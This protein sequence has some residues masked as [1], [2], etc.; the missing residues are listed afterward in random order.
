MSSLKS[1]SRIRNPE[2]LASLGRQLRRA[3]EAAGLAQSSVKNM[4]QGT[5]SKIENGLEVTLDTFVTYTTSL[6]L[7]I[8]LVPVG[9]AALLQSK[10]SAGD[11]APTDLLTEFGHLTDPE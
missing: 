2:A 6:G 10:R 11:A 8:A 5:V 1:S 3:R 9:Q 7:E 4:R